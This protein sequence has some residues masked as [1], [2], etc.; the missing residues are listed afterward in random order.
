MRWG[1]REWGFLRVGWCCGSNGEVMKEK[2]IFGS[3]VRCE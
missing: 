3:V 2:S 1:Q